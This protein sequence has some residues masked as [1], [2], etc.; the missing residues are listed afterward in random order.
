MNPFKD[1]YL[2]YK[3]K[4]KGFKN[5]QLKANSASPKAFKGILMRAYWSNN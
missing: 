3:Q 1:G 5:I 2:F 4:R